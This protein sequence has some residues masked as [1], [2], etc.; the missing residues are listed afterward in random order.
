MSDFETFLAHIRKIESVL[1]EAESARKLPDTRVHAVRQIK[2][3]FDNSY[4]GR[5]SDAHEAIMTRMREQAEAEERQAGEV[6]R[7]R[8]LRRLAVELEALRQSLP[9]LA[10]KARFE[11]CDTA[12]EMRAA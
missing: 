3:W 2:V 4:G 8:E 11:L 5:A 1:R 6:A 7:S 10:V 9:D 12:R